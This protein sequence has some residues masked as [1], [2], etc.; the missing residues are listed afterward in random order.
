MQ[1]KQKVTL[2][3]PPDLH[4]MLKIK[5]A[6]EGEPM[7]AIAER[8]I[9]FYLKNPHVVD[10]VEESQGKTHQV[11][12]CPGCDKPYVIRDDQ[13]VPLGEQPTILEED[14]LTITR[15]PGSRSDSGKQ[16]EEEL[17]PC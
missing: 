12:S 3:I 1:D 7:S 8:A 11:Y 4:R 17:V 16:G 14:E 15:V 10:E 9:V 5:A 13:M 2:Y 6:V